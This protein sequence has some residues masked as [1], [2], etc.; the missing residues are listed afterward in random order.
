MKITS[1]IVAL[2]FAVTLLSAGTAF[3]GDCRQVKFQMTNNS[4][5]K[6]KVKSIYIQGNDGSWTENI[7]NKQI[8][9]GKVYTTGQRK[10]NELD[11]GKTGDFKLNYDRWDANNNKWQT[12]FQKYTGRKCTDGETFTWKVTNK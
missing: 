8:D 11:S 6:I 12:K 3:A 7:G 1:K 5:A 2:T 9:S 10:L 4:G